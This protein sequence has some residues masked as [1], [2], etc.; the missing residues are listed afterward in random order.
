MELNR[1][2]LAPLHC[3]STDTTRLNLAALRFEEDGRTVATN[4]H[5][6]ALFIPGKEPE[7]DEKLEPFSLPADSLKD[8]VKEQRKRNPKDC[9]VD[10]EATKGA[11]VCRTFDPEPLGS[12]SEL[13]K[14]QDE[15][16]GNFPKWEA[17]MP[18]EAPHYSVN[19]S[20]HV[21]EQLIAAAR[22]FS[23]TRKGEQQNVRFDFAESE[24]NVVKVTCESKDDS[25][26][27]LEVIMMPC[28]L[29]D[30]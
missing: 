12:T 14:L 9:H 1:K 26:D 11:R 5:T 27:R 6:L 29:L 15:D 17:V 21:L 10:V 20:L 23:G 30:K 8:I 16:G 4:G 2:N 22:Q 3:A 19:L 28:R 25:E 13:P 24:L 7:A 18:K